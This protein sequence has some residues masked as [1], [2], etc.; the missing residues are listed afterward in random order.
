MKH[1]IAPVLVVVACIAFFVFMGW[2][3]KMRPCVSTSCRPTWASDCQCIHPE[4]RIEWRGET[5]LCTCE[6]KL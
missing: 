1:W 3:V 2:A 5:M 4:H 6:E